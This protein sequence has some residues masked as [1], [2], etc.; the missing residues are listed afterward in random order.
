MIEREDIEFKIGEDIYPLKKIEDIKTA[1]YFF[2]LSIIED[3]LEDNIFFRSFMKVFTDIPD[4]IINILDVEDFL[5][6]DFEYALKLVVSKHL[7]EKY[8]GYELKDFHKLTLGE[9][10][11][12]DNWLNSE[13]EKSIQKAVSILLCGSLELL[14]AVDNQRIDDTLCII[15]EFVKHQ[16]MIYENY[17]ILF[18]PDEDVD[19]EDEGN[20][21]GWVGFLFSLSENYLDAEELV[22]KN[23]ISIL[24]YT[25]WKIEKQK[26][27][28]HNSLMESAR[29]H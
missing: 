14:D 23:F 7:E 29:K 11:D 10:L 21:W 1:D 17:S 3:E 18:V 15:Q 5:I 20:K 25:K 13:T 12:V 8:L 19:E 24:N 27:S 2:I 26:E 16:K 22:K 9:W 28:E 4:D 6:I